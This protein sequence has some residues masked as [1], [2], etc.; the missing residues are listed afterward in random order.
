M[1]AGKGSIANDIAHDQET[2]LARFVENRRYTGVKP[3]K[4]VLRLPPTANLF[5]LSELKEK[6]TVASSGESGT[7]PADDT[8]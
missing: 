6:R 4:A 5:P 1:G 3:H 2:H 7:V 8:L